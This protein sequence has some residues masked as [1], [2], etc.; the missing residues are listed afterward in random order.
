MERARRLAGHLAV[1]L[2][3]DEK[4]PPERGA[5]TWIQRQG[6]SPTRPWHVTWRRTEWRS[7]GSASQESG[8]CTVVESTEGTAFYA[9][10]LQVQRGLTPPFS[11]SL[12]VLE[13][14]RENGGQ[15]GADYPNAAPPKE[16]LRAWAAEDQPLSMMLRAL[17]AQAPGLSP[18]AQMTAVQHA[19][20]LEL[21]EL[22]PAGAFC[23]GSLSAAELDAALGPVMRT[24][25]PRWALALDLHRA[26][27]LGKSIGPVLHQYYGTVQGSLE[28]ARGVR[29]AFDLSLSTTKLLIDMACKHDS[30]LD[31][32]FKA[33]L[34]ARQNNRDE[35]DAIE[36]A[37][38]KLS[39]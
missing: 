9:A 14:G 16:T 17:A 10:S 19:L 4:T 27:A 5:K 33:V 18:L 39:G 24:R 36:A 38:E 26:N 8:E 32:M 23:R 30:K 20:F 12:K 15:Y 2:Y 7:D 22:A 1:P 6:P 3:P 37:L 11:Y 25:R 21:D 35:L 13:T 31:V 29:D 34:C 28:L